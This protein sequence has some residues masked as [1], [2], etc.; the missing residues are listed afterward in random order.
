MRKFG[1]GGSLLTPYHCIQHGQILIV[2]DFG[3]DSIKMF[4]LKGKFISKFGKKGEKD[5]EFNNPR[6]LSVNKE[7][8]LT[9]CDGGNHRV[10]VFKLSGKFVS[11]FGSKGDERG[12]FKDPVCTGYLS[13]GRVVVCDKENHRIQVFDQI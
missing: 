4:D 11:N 1:G 8:S 7:G 2:S 3:D 5:E 10:Q 13:D 12:E 9:V 6:Y